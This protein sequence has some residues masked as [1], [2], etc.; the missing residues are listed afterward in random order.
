MCKYN[1]FNEFCELFANNSEVYDLL[2]SEV[3]HDAL[4]GDEVK[5]SKSI[6]LSYEKYVHLTWKNMTKL[7]RDKI[8]T[9]NVTFQG[10]QVQLNQIANSA[11]LRHLKPPQNLQIFNKIS[12][13]I[14]NQVNANPSFIVDRFFELE[15]TKITSRNLTTFYEDDDGDFNSYDDFKDVIIEDY[16]EFGQNTDSPFGSGI[17]SGFSQDGQVNENVKNDEKIFC[18]VQNSNLFLLSDLSAALV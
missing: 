1:F 17:S 4:G 6:K 11:A 12:L 8:L 3:I 16:Q 18:E 7:L 14:S 9:S 10:Q 5:L 13:N 15:S 2:T